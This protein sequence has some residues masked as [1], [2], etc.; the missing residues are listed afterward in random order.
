VEQQGLLVHGP[1]IYGIVIAVPDLVVSDGTRL[2][3]RVGG[4]PAAPRFVILHGL[5]SDLDA[6]AALV[7]AIGDRLHVVRLDLRG[8][9][10]S[11]PLTD[12]ARYGWFDRAATDVVELLDALAWPTADLCGG[13]LGAAVST[14]TVLAHPERVRSLVLLAPAIGGGPALGNS[15]AAGFMQGARDLGLIGLLDQLVAAVPDFLPPEQLERTRATWG[16]QDD[17]A[18][19]ACVTALGE[20]QLVADLAELG[21]I[22]R[23]TMV[24]GRRGDPLHPFELAEEYARHI[25]GARLV[26]DDGEVPLHL[27]PAALADLLVGFRRV[28]LARGT[29]VF[30]AAP[31]RGRWRMLQSPDDVLELMDTSA[32]G[33]IACVA[34]AGATFLAPIFDELV[35]VVCLSGTPLS[36]VG[37][38]SREYQVPCLMGATIGDAPAD[39]TEVEVDCS[40]GE[41]VVRAVS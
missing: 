24:V 27:R 32:V 40:G 19:R 30:D 36:H 11:E 31:V 29:K 18:M 8:H 26:E 9:G 25:P 20:A 21:R 7:D 2:H 14:A 6:D 41:G 4:S 39:G 12:P 15:V 5:G 16:R 22:A 1:R 23:P 13:S 34:D 17:A 28:E 33:V 3:Y 10:H 38:V 35:A 37:I